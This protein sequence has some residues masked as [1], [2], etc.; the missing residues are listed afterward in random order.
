MAQEGACCFGPYSGAAQLRNVRPAVVLTGIGT[1][2]HNIN[3]NHIKRPSPYREVN[4][5]HLNYKNQPVN[6]VQ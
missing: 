2:K 6:A 5:L 1:L 3:P 4:T